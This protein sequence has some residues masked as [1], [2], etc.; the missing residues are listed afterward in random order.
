MV[1]E[2]LY[3]RERRDFALPERPHP[4]RLHLHHRHPALY[5]LVE[6]H[7]LVCRMLKGYVADDIRCDMPS[8]VR[9][10]FLHLGYLLLPRHLPGWC[11]SLLQKTLWNCIRQLEW[12][13]I[14]L[15]NHLND[16]SSNDRILWWAHIWNN[17]QSISNTVLYLCRCL[18]LDFKRSNECEQGQIPWRRVGWHWQ[19]QSR[20]K[21]HVG[22]PPRLL[23][24][25]YL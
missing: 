2:V 4:H 6:L 17:S 10:S 8:P 23:V 16:Y 25:Y 5:A 22:L 1:L 21:D 7:L 20:Q 11:Q 24:L 13:A 15:R 19:T 9:Q 18:C 3:L 12:L 14:N